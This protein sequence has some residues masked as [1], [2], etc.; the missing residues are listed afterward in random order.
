MTGGQRAL[1]L[2]AEADA[3]QEQDHTHGGARRIDRQG[4]SLVV[5]EADRDELSAHERCLDAI[6]NASGAEPVWR[7][8]LGD[9]A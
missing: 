5:L 8:P 4:L 9:G 7:R 3:A 1:S 2:D 6:A